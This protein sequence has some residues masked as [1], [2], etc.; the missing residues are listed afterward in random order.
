MH[1]DDQEKN[2][3]MTSRDIYQ[4]YA[5]GLKNKC[6]TYK[7]LINMMFAEYLGPN[8]KIYINDILIK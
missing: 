7:R 1:P 8:M 4:G 6:F 2:S 5:F 3:F